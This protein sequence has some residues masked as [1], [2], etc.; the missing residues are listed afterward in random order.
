MSRSPTCGL[1]G[2]TALS[3]RMS[4][5][6]LVSR[7]A[8]EAPAGPWNGAASPRQAELPGASVRARGRE[9]DARDWR[10]LRRHRGTGCCVSASRGHPARPLPRAT[11][12][13]RAGG[14]AAPPR[15]RRPA[16]GAPP[17]NL[18]SVSLREGSFLLRGRSGDHSQAN[19]GAFS[20][21]A[22]IR[23]QDGV[24]NAADS[25]RFSSRRGSGADS[26]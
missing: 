1:H 16:T 22:S 8:C 7:A 20:P 6:C 15:K 25:P 26:R 10:S 4:V 21:T 14:S 9:R 3:H 17:D 23:Q 18:R 19:T 11:R 5:P 24:G 13:S 12:H 2:A